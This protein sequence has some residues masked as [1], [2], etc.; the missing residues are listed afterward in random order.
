MTRQSLTEKQL[1]FVDE[2]LS[3]FN[4]SAAIL[5][6]GYDTKH[7]DKMGSQLLGNPRV[8]DAIVSRRL[9]IAGKRNVDMDFLVTSLVVEA[10]YY[11]IDSSHSARI[12]ALVHL[13]KLTGHYVER[14]EI[15]INQ[16]VTHQLD[17][18]SET[19]LMALRNQ[20][21]LAIEAEDSDAVEG[22][23]TETP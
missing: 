7:P 5:R 22:E 3:S 18:L 8:A 21:M 17:N 1:A 11:G 15:D 20:A 4:A 16:H 10:T 13:A 14:K 19:E 2:Y 6:A 23:Y 9:E 12:Q